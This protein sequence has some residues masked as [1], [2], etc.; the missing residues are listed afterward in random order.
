MQEACQYRDIIFF[1]NY[2]RK[3]KGSGCVWMRQPTRCGV[4]AELPT[5]IGNSP[6]PT[7]THSPT[8]KLQDLEWPW[9]DLV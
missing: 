6:S 7:R 9:G 1:L 3:Q 5:A 4:S 8:G 2:V